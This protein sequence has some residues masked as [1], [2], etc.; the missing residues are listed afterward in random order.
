MKLHNILNEEFIK[1]D[2]TAATA[3][4]ALKE[5]IDCLKSK[6]KITNE[7]MTLKKLMEREKLGSTSI[8]KHSAVP[9]AKLKGI[10]EPIIY[11]AISKDGILYNKKDKTIVHLIILILSPID[12][13]I[14]HL[15]ILAAAASLIKKSD[16]F[17]KEM[18]SIESPEELLKI[19]KKYESLND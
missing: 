1:T 11:I 10:K 9:H 7:N 8:G 13:P 3:E 2:C 14:I 6:N 5:M 18:L 17:I 4:D 19:I 16:K 15:Q 12:A